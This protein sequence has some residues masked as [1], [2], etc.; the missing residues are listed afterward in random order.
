MVLETVR[1]GREVTVL[2]E[3]PSGSIRRQSSQEPPLHRR[4]PATWRRY[5]VASDSLSWCQLP[6]SVTG[7]DA[8]HR[9]RVAAFSGRIGPRGSSAGRKLMSA[10]LQDLERWQASVFPGRT[11]RH[12]RLK[13]FSSL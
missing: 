8:L 1:A 7:A 11:G 9:P 3:G 13:R 5:S 10:R 12:T 2:R 4:A 6:W